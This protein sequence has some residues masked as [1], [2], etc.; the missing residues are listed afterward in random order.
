MVLVPPLAVVTV[1]ETGD[2][3][4]RVATDPL[5]VTTWIEVSLAGTEV[6]VVPPAGV[7][8]WETTGDEATGMVTST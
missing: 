6:V 3:T 4:W 8:T 1:S 7:R 2:G 5:E